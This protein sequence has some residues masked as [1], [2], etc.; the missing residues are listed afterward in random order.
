MRGV[1]SE[2]S[3]WKTNPKVHCT[4]VILTGQMERNPHVYFT[5]RHESFVYKKERK[6]TPPSA[7][8]IT[9]LEMN[10]QG[11]YSC[12]QLREPSYHLEI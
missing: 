3:R 7:L 1:T 12:S 9:A 11:N 4:Q 8:K 10:R 2:L 6:K 5:A